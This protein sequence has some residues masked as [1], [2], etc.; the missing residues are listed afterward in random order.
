MV[1]C[2]PFCCKTDAK[3]FFV[4]EEVDKNPVEGCVPPEA[5]DSLR[6]LVFQMPQTSR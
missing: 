5:G 1:F 4:H 2:F 3:A 6:S